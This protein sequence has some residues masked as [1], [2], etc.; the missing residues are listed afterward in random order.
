MTV[1]TVEPPGIGTPTTPGIETA[2][3]WGLVP[4]DPAGF[5]SLFP[6]RPDQE[7]TSGN[8]SG[9]RGL[10]VNKAMQYLGTPYKWGGT[11]PS[12]FDCSGFIQYVAGQFGIDLPRISFQQANSGPRI[13]IEDLKPGDV[14]ASDNSPRNDGADHI[15]WYAGDGYIIEAPRSGLNVRR[16]KMSADEGWYGVSLAAFYGE[17]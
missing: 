1:E 2:Q 15:A 11:G 4:L 16:R 13:S 8:V 17:S 14:V 9:K 5:S 6:A 3:P 7:G 10:V 12:G